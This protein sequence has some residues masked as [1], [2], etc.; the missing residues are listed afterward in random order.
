MGLKSDSKVKESR[1]FIAKLLDYLDEAKKTNATDPMFT[2]EKVGL[3]Y[4]E[5][6]ALDM[7]ATA[8]KKDES[9]DFSKY[10]FC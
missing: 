10:G 2:E 3:Q 4:V 5:N 8:F 9:G 7:F 1:D 6:Q